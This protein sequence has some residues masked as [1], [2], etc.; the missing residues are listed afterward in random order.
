MLTAP[1]IMIGGTARV[2]PPISFGMVKRVAPILEAMR[3]APGNL[4]LRGLVLDAVAVF[5]PADRATL[6]EEILYVETTALLEQWGSILIWSGLVS[7][8]ATAPGEA[9]AASSPP[10]ASTI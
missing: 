10:S 8:E 9:P 4:E 5:L 1:A 2:L 7:A 3:T 6:E